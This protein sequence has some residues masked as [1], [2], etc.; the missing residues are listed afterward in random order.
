MKNYIAKSIVVLIIISLTSGC[1]NFDDLRDNPNNPN[2]V[3]PSLLFTAVI[4]TPISSFSDEYINSQYHLWSAVDNA[5]AVSYRFGSGTFSY[6]TLRNID[7]MEKEA[8][9]TNAP[10]YSIMAKFLRAYNYVEM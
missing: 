8:A 10:V 9:T 4:P 5:S 6:A 7:K 2:K 3:R 1:K